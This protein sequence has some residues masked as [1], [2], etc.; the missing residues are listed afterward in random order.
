M[1]MR[2]GSFLDPNYA[3]SLRVPGLGDDEEEEYLA[4]A[5][6]PAPPPS[7][8]PIA[9]APP[10]KPKSALEQMA[11]LNKQ[12]PSQSDPLLKPKPIERIGGILAGAAL[13]AGAGY[14]NSGRR[15]Q[16]VDP[17]L[18]GN[19]GS[20]IVNR[21]YN[22]ANRDFSEK[23]EGLKKQAG[24]ESQQQQQELTGL[25][26][27]ATV[28]NINSQVEDRKAKAEDRDEQ[29]K[30]MAEGRNLQREATIGSMGAE[31]V[32]GT[33]PPRDINSKEAPEY[34]YF[35]VD[36]KTYRR[37]T[38]YAK[39]KWKKEGEEASYR[40]VPPAIAK[41]LGLPENTKVPPGELD[42]YLKMVE[43]RTAREAN[44]T[45]RRD[46]QRESIETRKAIAAVASS[47]RGSQSDFRNTMQMGNAYKS[48]PAIKQY[49]EVKQAYDAMRSAGNDGPGDL[50]VLRYFAK[51]TDPSTGVRE[52]EYR[53]MA[54]AGGVINTMQV[55]ASG[56]WT[57]GKKLSP[58]TREAFMRIAGEIAKNREKTV[59]GLK[60]VYTKRAQKFGVDPNLIFEADA[61]TAPNAPPAATQPAQPTETP[62][63]MRNPKTGEVVELRNGQWVKVGK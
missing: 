39:T 33:A 5:A 61:P 18:A 26:K 30:S 60:N 40:P 48:E 14:M 63:Q 53:D 21:R 17:N 7:I 58:Q 36:G 41:Q 3:R 29:R 19:V 47:N 12:R 8:A 31:L 46:L 20:A 15:G 1:A 13:G 6:Y 4:S 38:E 45:M 37:P 2:G 28:E 22:N 54:G 55:Y 32:N 35:E 10:Q 42:S 49:E 44:E 27:R 24:I 23:E 34:S 50:A 11:D 57:G 62:K 25:T 59:S 52:G 56:G 51:I 9:P 16:V 43:A